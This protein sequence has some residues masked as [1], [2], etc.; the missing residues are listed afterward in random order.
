MLIEN[1]DLTM[2]HVGLGELNEYA[3]MVLF[4]NAHSHHLVLDL[5]INPSQIES[6][7]GAKL[8]PAYFMTRLKVPLINLLPN[9]KL[10]QTVSIAVDVQRFGDT[11]LESNYIIGQQGSFKKEVETWNKNEFPTMEGNNL[12]VK[13]EM[14]GQTGKRQISNPNPSKIS[15]L[16][17]TRRAPSGLT[18]SR[19]IR[20]QGFDDFVLSPQFQNLQPI[21]YQVK[22]FRDALAGHAMIFAKYS[23][24]MDVIEYDFLSQQLFPAI[25]DA[26]LSTLNIIE[27]DI[28]Y[29]GNCYAGEELAINLCGEIEFADDD[30][31]EELSFIAAG[32]LLINFEIY[33]K[34]TR[35]LVAISRVKKVFAVEMKDQE[36]IA[37]LRRIVGKH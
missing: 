7:D 6:D 12:I 2:S 11:L 28:Y 34:R 27:R 25:P 24:I 8:Y 26:L 16:V 3:L 31:A 36:I 37:D 20:K 10:W 18:Q 30:L 35:A 15:E 5:T 14:N 4:G 13:E 23:E 29:Y 32:Y 33:Q 1:I 19:K 21:I 9:F 17:K 22:P